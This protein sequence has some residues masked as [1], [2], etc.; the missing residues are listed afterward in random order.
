MS[1]RPLIVGVVLML[2]V[3]SLMGAYLWGLRNRARIDARASYAQ[4]VEPPAAGPGEPVTLYV[5]DDDP[6]M[7]Y[8]EKSTISVSEGRQQR[9]EELLR[10]LVTL[11][12]DKSSPHLLGPGSEVRNVYLVEPGLAVIDLNADFANGHRSGVLVE[13]LTIASLVVRPWLA[14]PISPGHTMCRASHRW[15]TPCRIRSEWAICKVPSRRVERNEQSYYSSRGSG[16]VPN[17]GFCI[18][19]SG[20]NPRWAGARSA[21]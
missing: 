4:P 21:R 20:R 3:A 15:R 10:A 16:S 9:C 1:S 6:G 2:T 13:E 19:R 14:T 17:I 7:L 8:P 18:L 5:A 12:L 11:Y